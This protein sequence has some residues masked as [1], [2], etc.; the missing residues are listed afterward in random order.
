[1]PAVELHP[2]RQELESF[3]LGRLADDSHAAV[4]RHLDACS[5]CQRVVDSVPG[6]ALVSL[7][8]STASVSDT[9]KALEGSE[10]MSDP[11]AALAPAAGSRT[12][13]W[14]AGETNA[15]PP[16][17]LVG[18]SKYEP[19]RRLGSG[20]MG[21]VWLARHRV[22]G[23]QVAVKVIRPEFVAK[24]GAAERFH[25]E[26]QAAAR[27]SHPNIVAAFDAEPAGDTHLLAMEYVDGINLADLVK[28]AA[29]CRSPRR[30]T[31]FARPRLDCSTPSIAA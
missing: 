12:G 18:H 2:S 25:R 6:D 5:A 15:G 13:A 9:I 10:T 21:T 14:E 27:L 26:A 11:P 17:V 4:E 19:T 23:R 31:R 30:A 20:G 24:P 8:R 16:A 28:D 1:M 29:P 22:M 3:G 7:L